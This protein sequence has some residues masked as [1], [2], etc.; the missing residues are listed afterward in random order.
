MLRT[1]VQPG[2]PAR[3]LA[4]GLA[5]GELIEDIY[6]IRRLLFIIY[7]II[8]P[9]DGWKTNV[10]AVTSQQ[11]SAAKRRAEREHQL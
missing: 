9:D 6:I 1:S 8:Q 4:G 5:S 11:E 7:V 3:L 10:S 2:G